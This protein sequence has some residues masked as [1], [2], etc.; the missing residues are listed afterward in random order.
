MRYKQIP[1]VKFEEAS[2]E[3]KQ[4]ILDRYRYFEVEDRDLILDDDI[5]IMKLKDIGFNVKH[6]QIEYDLSYSQ[7]SGAC[8]DCDEFDF[9]LLLKDFELRHKRAIIDIIKDY[10]AYA[11]NC[12]GYA[13]HYCHE[14]TRY[15]EIKLCSHGFHYRI[16]ELLAE[17]AQHIEG[18]RLDASRELYHDLLKSY[19]YFTSDEVIAEAMIANEYEFNPDGEIDY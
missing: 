11:I 19:E 15:F 3:L 10:C 9:D 6:N 2:E 7:G 18:I 4:K 13:N 1:L 12:N 5:H 16:E 8:F 17:V 14:K